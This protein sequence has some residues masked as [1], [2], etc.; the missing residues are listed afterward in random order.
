ML[1]WLNK[2]HIFHVQGESIPCAF[3]HKL[4]TAGV[5]LLRDSRAKNHEGGIFYTHCIYLD[6][7]NLMYPP[8]RLSPVRWGHTI[9]QWVRLYT[10]LPVQSL[11]LYSVS[12][13]WS[14]CLPAGWTCQSAPDDVKINNGGITHCA[15][16]LACVSVCVRNGIVLFCR[17]LVPL[18][19]SQEVCINSGKRAVCSTHSTNCAHKS[20]RDI[21]LKG[22]IRLLAKKTPTR[23]THLP[24][25]LSVLRDKWWNYY[26]FYAYGWLQTS[27]IMVSLF[28]IWSPVSK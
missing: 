1:K 18:T 12:V 14:V 6:A 22:F 10:Y 11:C 28:L 19:R 27:L 20:S 7:D 15:S 24:H 23:P 21:F 8:C 5:S 16:M 9:K 4:Y 26:F 17:C 13:P 2:I 25:Y 3:L